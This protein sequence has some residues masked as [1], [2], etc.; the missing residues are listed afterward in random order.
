MHEILGQLP[1]ILPYLL[2]YMCGKLPKISYTNFA[3][4]MA[5]ANSAEPDQISGRR[6]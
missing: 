4:I 2:Y 3:D 5:Y 1:Q 6:V